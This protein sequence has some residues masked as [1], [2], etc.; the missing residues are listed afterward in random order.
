MA[1]IGL[2]FLGRTAVVALQVNHDIAVQTAD[3][4]VSYARYFTTVCILVVTY[5]FILM[6][7]ERSAQAHHR[8]MANRGPPTGMV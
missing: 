1:G 2:A 7:A 4:A 6:A 8:A 3:I 5:G